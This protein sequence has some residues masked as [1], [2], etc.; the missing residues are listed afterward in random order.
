METFFQISGSN[1][2]LSQLQ[3]VN[4]EKPFKDQVDVL[5]IEFI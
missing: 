2:T 5:L 1:K 4:K 3:S